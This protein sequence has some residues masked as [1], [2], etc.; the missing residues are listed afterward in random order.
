MAS[1]ASFHKGL[2][3]LRPSSVPGCARLMKKARGL[4]QKVLGRPTYALQTKTPVHFTLTAESLL[5]RGRGT[6]E[7]AKSSKLGMN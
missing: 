2:K 3:V 1:D 6:T 5:R 4:I 7:K